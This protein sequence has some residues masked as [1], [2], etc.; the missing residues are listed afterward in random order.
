[1]VCSYAAMEHRKVKK[2][3]LKQGENIELFK[4]TNIMCIQWLMADVFVVIILF[5]GFT[6]YTFK[7]KIVDC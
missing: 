6:R 3:K 1:M 7:T 2:K 4:I 5:T